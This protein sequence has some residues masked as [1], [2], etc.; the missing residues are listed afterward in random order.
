ME[1]T[2]ESVLFCCLFMDVCH[3]VVL[4]KSLMSCNF[5]YI[6][7]HAYFIQTNQP[8]HFDVCR[9]CSVYVSTIIVIRWGRRRTQEQAH[10]QEAGRLR[11]LRTF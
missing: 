11:Q 3:W 8:D 4:Y 9:K 6:Y 1:E 10:M 5:G 2:K 7:E